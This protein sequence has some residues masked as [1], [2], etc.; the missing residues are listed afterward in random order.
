MLAFS[1]FFSYQFFVWEI[2][3][4]TPPPSLITPPLS[5]PPMAGWSLRGRSQKLPLC[6]FGVHNFLLFFSTLS[7]IATMRG[8]D[9]SYFCLSRRKFYRSV[10]FVAFEYNSYS[11]FLS[12]LRKPVRFC[13]LLFLDAPVNSLFYVFLPW[14]RQGW[15]ERVN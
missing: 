7:L 3:L 2:S 13:V 5:L 15:S 14:F 10:R 11:A 4:I 12:E 9:A 8:K 6:P 1:F